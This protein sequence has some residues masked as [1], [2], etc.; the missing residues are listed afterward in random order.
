MAIGAQTQ[1]TNAVLQKLDKLIKV[2]SGVELNALDIQMVINLRKQTKL[3]EV[4]A[5]KK[6]GAAGATKAAGGKADKLKEGGDALKLLGVG[7]STLAKGMLIFSLV[8]KAGIRKFRNA[9]Y[10]IF[11]IMKQFVVRK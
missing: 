5:A 8:P 2:S 9:L 3:L 1:G 11:D 10:D 7:A 4:I 6:G